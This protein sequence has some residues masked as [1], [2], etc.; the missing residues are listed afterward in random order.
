MFKF[1][2]YLYQFL[3]APWLTALVLICFS[4]QAVS[5]D[6]VD[7]DTFEKTSHENNGG[8][9]V[10]GGTRYEPPGETGQEGS[11]DVAGGARWGE[12]HPGSQIADVIKDDCPSTEYPLI[13]LMPSVNW[14]RTYTSNP[15]FWIYVPYTATQA[16]RGEFIFRDRRNPDPNRLDIEIEFTLPETPGF[17]SV[18]LPETA[19]TLDTNTEY[20]WAFN[21]YC[22]A[23]ATTPLIVDGWVQRFEPGEDL[24]QQ[25]EVGDNWSDYRLY[26]DN[27]IWLDAIDALMQERL[28]QPN[29]PDLETEWLNLLQDGVLDTN[30]DGVVDE[31][32]IPIGSIAGSVELSN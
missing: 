16:P 5:S 4:F 11:T 12:Q 17:V 27:F 28:A 2:Q 26:R 21:L 8:I 24:S 25:L 31:S 10:P 29:N 19:P 20:Y 9:D 15:T 6:D 32:D 3:L 30:E 1:Q 22:G 7:T 18:T 23:D 14:S 13:A